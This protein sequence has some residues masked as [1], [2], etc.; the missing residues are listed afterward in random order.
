LLLIASYFVPSGVVA[1]D[2]SPLPQQFVRKI[3]GKFFKSTQFVAEDAIWAEI[4]GKN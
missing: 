1:G 3:V 2:Y 4:R